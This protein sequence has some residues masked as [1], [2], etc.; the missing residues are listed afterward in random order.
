MVGSA[1][2]KYFDVTALTIM[3]KHQP[4]VVSRSE[5]FE[6]RITVSRANPFAASKGRWAGGRWISLIEM[7]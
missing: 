6:N 5:P 7:T 3:A 2:H 4:L 1:R